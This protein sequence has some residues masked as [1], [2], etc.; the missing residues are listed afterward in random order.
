MRGLLQVVQ[1][2]KNRSHCNQFHKWTN[3]YGWSRSRDAIIC[4]CSCCYMMVHF[5]LHNYC[6]W[7][8]IISIS[9]SISISITIF[10]IIIVIGTFVLA[11]C[12][13]GCYD[14]IV[15]IFIDSCSPSYTIRSSWWRHALYAAEV[16]FLLPGEVTIN[17]CGYHIIFIFTDCAS[18][19]E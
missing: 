7:L 4:S 5:S 2:Q 8:Y 3:C 14:W 9:I 10:I 13:C 18:T 16:L 6:C 17:F 12:G 19:R 15:K 1:M 11:G